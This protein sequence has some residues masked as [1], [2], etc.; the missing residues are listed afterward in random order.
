MHPL[1]DGYTAR[2]GRLED[3]PELASLEGRYTT[4][5]F[6]RTLRTEGELRTEWQAPSF[7]PARDT[8][9]VIDP[10]GAIVGW[11]EVYDFEPHVA[12]P[13]RLRVAPDTPESVASHLVGWSVER[14]RHSISLAP[15]GARVSVTQSA[16]DVDPP[17]NARLLAAGFSPIRV[18]LRMQIEL[19]EMPL[20]PVWPDSISVRTF[21]A[22]QDDLPAVEAM[23]EAFADHWGH[24]ETPL[25][26]DLEEWRQWIYEDEDFDTDLWFLAE[27]AGEIVGFCQCYPVSG[28]DPRVGLVDELGVLRSHRGQGLATALLQHAFRTFAER[29]KSIV[30]LGVDAESL[31]GATRLYEKVGMHVVRRTNVYE[32]ELRPG[33]DIVNRG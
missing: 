25:E 18:F 31:T 26:E 22:G 13:S 10:D 1:P 4:A 12:L 32:F 20:A 5:L 23:R 9:I 3:V 14:A 11:I 30:E 8:Q 24:V 7:D 21:I 15:E 6:G 17:A 28:D 29:G 19:D 33:E 2:S 16:F 27:E